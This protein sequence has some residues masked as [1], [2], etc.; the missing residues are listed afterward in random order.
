MYYYS[1]ELII[2]DKS[3]FKLDENNLAIKHTKI[4][5]EDGTWRIEFIPIIPGVH[6]INRIM[7]ENNRTKSILLHRINVVNYGE[8]RILYGYKFYEMHESIQ[9]VFDAANFKV[10]DI[11]PELKSKLFP[12]K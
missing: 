1:V 11:L 5:K 3:H 6:L 2:F 12:Q 8:Q 9:L 4:Q 10:N 7:Y